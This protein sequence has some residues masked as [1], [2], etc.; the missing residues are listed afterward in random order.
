MNKTELEIITEK[1]LPLNLDGDKWPEGVSDEQ[2][3]SEMKGEIKF[4]DLNS[5]FELEKLLRHR[6][7]LRK[8]VRMDR[9]YMYPSES[10]WPVTDINVQENANEIV[11]KSIEGYRVRFVGKESQIWGISVGTFRRSIPILDENA[12]KKYPVH[13]TVSEQEIGVK[14]TEDTGALYADTYYESRTKFSD[15]DSTKSV[16]DILYHFADSD[17]GSWRN[18]WDRDFFKTQSRMISPRGYAQDYFGVELGTITKI[19]EE[20]PMEIAR[21]LDNDKGDTRVVLD[22]IQKLQRKLTRARYT[23]VWQIR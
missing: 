20:N 11:E 22:R 4:D 14:F 23:S 18:S 10:Y 3:L 1:Q 7:F 13:Q 5:Q 16:P 6:T 9:S 19:V 2:V 17:L 12:K 15:G 21:I 8:H